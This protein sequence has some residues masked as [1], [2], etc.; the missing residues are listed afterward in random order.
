LIEGP[1]SLDSGSQ[2]HVHIL[3][4]DL[5][6]YILLMYRTRRCPQVRVPYP[7]HAMFLFAHLFYLLILYVCRLGLYLS[8]G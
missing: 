8:V 7:P 1:C 2:F 3:C 6:Y 5:I 4:F